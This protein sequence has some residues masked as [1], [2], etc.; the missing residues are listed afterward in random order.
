MMFKYCE[1]DQCH[2]CSNAVM[3]KA[4][5]IHNPAEGRYTDE[6]A[7]EWNPLQLNFVIV[8]SSLCLPN[9]VSMTF[10][11]YCFLFWKFTPTGVIA[12]SHYTHTGG[13]SNLLCLPLEPIYDLHQPGVQTP[14]LIYGTEMETNYMTADQEWKNLQDQGPPC[15]VCLA[16]QKP[17]ILMI[18]ARNVC[19]SSNWTLEYSG[20][21]MADHHTHKRNEYICVD[22]HPEVIPR[23]AT[24]TNGA[25][26]YVVEAAC[27]NANSLP[28]GPY[29]SGH[30]LTC[31]VCSL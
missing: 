31:A 18:P 25:L 9:F 8:S 19:P 11:M 1:L 15:A 10:P 22:R 7:F 2:S 20:Q 4:M 26:L 24:D 27:T 13:G 5:S 21:L 12:G 28:C 6:Y 30:E 14:S 17:T 23:T 3:P 16:L 29:I